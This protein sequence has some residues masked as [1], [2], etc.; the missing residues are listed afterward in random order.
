MPFTPA[1]TCDVTIDVSHHQGNIDWAAVKQTGIQCVMIKATQGLTKDSLWE[2]N[3]DGAK[4]QG[5]LVIPYTFLTKAAGAAAQAQFFVETAGLMAGMLA[6][7]DWEGDNAPDAAFVEQV[8]LAV[9]E[10]I[11][12]DPLGYW[13][14]S[15]PAAPTAVMKGWPRW[16]PRYGANDGNPDMNHQPTEPWLFWQYTSNQ[17]VDG[18]TGSVDASLFAGSEA[19]LKAWCETGALPGIGV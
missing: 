19:A 15:P 3:R 5:L 14:G 6:A 7:L 1:T 9:V 4:A 18:I 16:I 10:V 12:R 11:R 13:G 8:G 17:E 2:V